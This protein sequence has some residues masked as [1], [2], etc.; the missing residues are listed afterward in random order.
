MAHKPWYCIG[1]AGPPSLSQS[2]G[3]LQS[4]LG[5]KDRLSPC[6]VLGSLLVTWL[7]EAVILVNLFGEIFFSSRTVVGK[8]KIGLLNLW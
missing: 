3:R 6:L 2:Q 5:R 7:R 8:G 4:V 1:A